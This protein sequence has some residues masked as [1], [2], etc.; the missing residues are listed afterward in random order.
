M[1]KHYIAMAGLCGYLPNY[2]SGP[3]QYK[4]QA[5][6]DLASLH[7]MSERAYKRL[8]RDM[9]IELDLAKQGNEYCE[10]V[11]CECDDPDCH[12]EL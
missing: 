9:Y 2:T 1:P 6:G 3:H 11:E 7:D 5:A 10:I 4:G 8:R 12:A